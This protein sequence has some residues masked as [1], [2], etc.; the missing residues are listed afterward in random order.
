MNLV[1]NI[2]T[3]LIQCILCTERMA[4]FFQNSLFLNTFLNSIW[5]LTTLWSKFSYLEGHQE[6]DVDIAAH[7]ASIGML[8]GMTYIYI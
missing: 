6:N 4:T 2:I 1:T 3:K 8:K 7:E 5:S